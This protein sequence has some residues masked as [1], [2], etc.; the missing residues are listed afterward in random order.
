MKT[1]AFVSL[2]LLL[3][4]L[5][6]AAT[7]EVEFVQPE[8]FSDIGTGQDAAAAQAALAQHLKSLGDKQ[9]PAQ[10]VLK[11]SITDVDLAGQQP[12]VGA[13]GN[14][15]RIMGKGADWP[16][17]NLRYQLIDGGKVVAE[18]EDKLTDMAYLDR[19]ST[20]RPNDPVPYENRML[21]T[22]FNARFRPAGKR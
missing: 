2:N 18:G 8:K 7:V 3:A 21:T 16:R 22:W 11:I 12:Q 17:I 15:L 4:G 10:Q 5:V 20:V 14:D 1:S 19:K 6:N 13:R 9:L